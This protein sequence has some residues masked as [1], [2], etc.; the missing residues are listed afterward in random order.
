MT[1]QLT[2]GQSN[3]PKPLMWRTALFKKSVLCLLAW[4]LTGVATA[5]AEEA[6]SPLLPLPLQQTLEGRALACP[7]LPNLDETDWQQLQTFYQQQGFIPLWNDSVRLTQLAHQ[8][9]SLADDGL[10]V[11]Q[12]QPNWLHQQAT[13]T[14]D[15]RTLCE[16]IRVSQLYLTGLRH[17][18]GGRLD[19]SRLEPL[20]YAEGAKR[21]LSGVL[22]AT[23]ALGVPAPAKAF[24]QARPTLDLYVN[25]RRLYA[26]LRHTAPSGGK[27]VPA[28]VSLRPGMEDERVPQ[29]ERLLRSSGY[30]KAGVLP[31]GSLLYS[32]TLAEAVAVFQRE[33]GLQADGVFGETTRTELNMGA[34]TR[35]EQLRINLERL[36]WVARDMEPT[37]LLVDVAG[38]RLIY[39]RDY[40]PIWWTRT[41]VGQPER[42]TPLLKSTVTRLTLNPTWTVPPTILREDKLPRIRQDAQYLKQHRIQVLDT[43]G[44]P[45]DPGGVDWSNPQGIRLRQEAGTGNPLGRVAI[46]FANPFSVYL[47]DTPSQHLFARAP[48]A[49]SSGCVRVESALKLV[50]MLITEEERPTVTRL[51]D[52]GKTHQYRLTEPLPILMAY[53]TAEAD[54]KGQVRY[55][56][57]IYQKD[58]ALLAALLSRKP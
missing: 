32:G 54:S 28:G 46:R 49:F 17:L 56:P 3:S 21:D 37:G 27:P 25:L 40:K 15:S 9:E 19:Q 47:H 42:A 10:D 45:L 43:E 38:A 39:Y 52:T 33:H 41:Q 55:R 4:S 44:Q 12:Y 48:R 26:R 13:I 14:P 22:L 20:W 53:W 11:A 34:V 24:E 35:L 50:D 23:A 1:A 8:L 18:L 29:I 2:A 31:K 36:R 58:P 51:L 5:L 6:T 16:D 30:L 57:D 7:D